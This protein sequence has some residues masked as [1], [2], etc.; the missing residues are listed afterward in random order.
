MPSFGRPGPAASVEDERDDGQDA[1]LHLEDAW[2]AIERQ[3]GRFEDSL[4]FPLVPHLLAM[5]L[6][7]GSISLSRS[8][9]CKMM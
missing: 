4:K 2:R 6:C 5:F 9:S 8:L 1:V 7:G 3:P